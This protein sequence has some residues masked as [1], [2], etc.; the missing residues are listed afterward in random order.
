MVEL[1]RRHGIVVWWATA[2]EIASALTRLVR[3][4]HLSPDDWVTSRRLA[5]DLAESWR[6]VQPSNSLRNRAIQLVARYELKAA[7]AL[8][9]SAALEWCEDLPQDRIFLA[10][11]QKL[12]EA[13]VLSGFDGMSL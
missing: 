3:M 9:L 8:Q 13:A 4:N 7:D 10:A 11:D 6:V 5:G 2:V 12:R 1:Y